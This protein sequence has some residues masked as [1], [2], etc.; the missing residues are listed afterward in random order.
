MAYIYAASVIIILLAIYLYLKLK[1]NKQDGQT[2]K[3]ETKYAIRNIA[4]SSILMALA[5]I[6]KIYGIMIGTDMRLAF[7]SVPL[8]LAGL[9]CGVDYGILAALGA[10]LVYSSV[11]GYAFNV[12]YTIGAILWGLL[13]GILRQYEINHKKI[14]IIIVSIGVVI[15]SLLET[16]I[17]L[18]S[19]LILY[20]Q[21]TTMLLLFYK[22]LIIIIK[23]PIITT[24]VILLY[25]RVVKK[26]IVDKK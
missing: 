4:L 13:G 16:H 15:A 18:L 5:A 10:D 25:K 9:V 7:Y 8:I 21:G 2:L 12:T 1:E 19:N 17:N 3:R 6:L 11:S 23:I 26:I 14:G 20:G 22:Y 24:L